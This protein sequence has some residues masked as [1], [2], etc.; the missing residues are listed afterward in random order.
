MGKYVW[1][2]VHMDRE[3]DDWEINGWS[4]GKD[5]FDH[6]YSALSNSMIKMWHRGLSKPDSILSFF[7][8][9]VAFLL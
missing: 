2:N 6:E 1:L 3:E 7:Q 9:L 8:F 4:Y 5:L